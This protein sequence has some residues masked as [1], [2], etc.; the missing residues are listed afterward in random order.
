MG[1]SCDPP[2]APGQQRTGLA[3]S[4]RIERYRKLA[5]DYSENELARFSLGKAYFDEGQFALA[6]EEFVGALARKPAWMAV[7]ILLGKCELA[8]GDRT[9]AK[10][11]L[12]RAHALAQQQRHAGPLA[13]TE[14]LL[15]QI[16][17]PE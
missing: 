14:Q 5:A 8:L 10:A 13:E 12:E 2:P 16:N 7:E 3:M 6:R 1:R 9:A 17:R 15:E 11:A 4:E